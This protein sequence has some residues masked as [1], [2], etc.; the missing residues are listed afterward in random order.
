MQSSFLYP[1]GILP[2]EE[3][4]RRFFKKG[5]ENIL[6]F[7]INVQFTF[8]LISMKSWKKYLLHFYLAV[9]ICSLTFEY[10]LHAELIFK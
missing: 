8:F 10:D 5:E 4:K 3:R 9:S 2:G 6:D 1:T 7:S